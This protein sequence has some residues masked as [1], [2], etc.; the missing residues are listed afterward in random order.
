MTR[1]RLA[2]VLAL[3]LL[4]PSTP[5]AERMGYPPAEFAARR[6]RLAQALQ[7][8]TG[9]DVRR[10][11][12]P[13][14]ACASGRTTTS[15]IS[16]ATKSLNG[17]LVMDAA[18]KASHLFLPKLSAD[19]GPLRGRQLARRDRTPRKATASRRFSRLPA[20]HEFLGRRRGVSGHRDALDAALRARRGRAAAASTRPSS[21]GAPAGQPVRAAAHRGRA[22]RIAT[23]RLQFPYYEFRD[24]TPHIDR[25][26]LIKTP[27]E[28]EILRYN[29]RISAE[30][31]KR[32]IQATAPGKYEYELEAEATYWMSSTGCRRR[33]TRPSSAR[34][35]WATS[36]TTR[37][38]AGR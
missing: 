36:G 9:R 3:A 35:R 37:T 13:R 22:A 16:P 12:A 15:S 26:R 24:V 17:V 29:G 10:H 34:D 30:A 28:I 2:A 21:T 23:L 14:R 32:A 5:G 20:L 8:G 18:T 19:A 6:Q 25:L 31:M 1:V 4:W 33:P 27:R 11:A 7:R 38:A